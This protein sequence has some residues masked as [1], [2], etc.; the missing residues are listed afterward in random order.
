MPTRNIL[1]GI[2]N[3]L[4]GD[5]GVGPWIA[6]SFSAPNWSAFDA[7]TAPENFTSLLR[8]EQPARVVLVDA[9][10]WGGQPGEC[11]RIPKDK[12]RDVG[13]GTH[14]LP[15]N[16]LMEYLEEFVPDVVFIGLQPGSLE[17]DCPLTPAVQDGASKLMD[18]LRNDQLDQIPSL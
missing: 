4:Q 9:A 2:G 8:R 6:R 1:L 11:R 18:L 16:H 13:I 14:Q 7:G 12:V 17:D 15:L 10:A 5:D 3:S